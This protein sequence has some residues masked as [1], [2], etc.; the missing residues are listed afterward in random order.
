M[1]K[2][3]ILVR[4][5]EIYLKGKNKP[6]FEKMLI[7]NIKKAIPD[8]AF[9]V[10][11]ISGRFLVSNYDVIKEK[12]LMSKL[13]KVFG[14]YSISSTVEMDTSVDEIRSYCREIKILESTFKVDVNRADKT[15]PIR[16]VPFAADLGGYVLENNPKLKVKL[17]DP[18]KIVFVDIRENGKTYIFYDIIKGVGGLPVG[19]SGRGLLLLSGGIDS[20]VAGYLMAKRGLSIDA[21]YFHSFPYT[22]E[23]VKE[24]VKKLAGILS[25][26]SGK[27][28]L[29]VVSFTKVQESIHEKCRPEYM[30][31]IMRRFMMRIARKLCAQN[32]LK[33]IITGESLAQVASQTVESMTVTGGVI[34]D[35]PV[36]RPLIGNDKEET[37]ELSEK[38]GAYETSILP[39][40]DCCTVF[41]PEHPLIKPK[42]D[43]VEKEES[44]LDINSLI[45][46]AMENIEIFDI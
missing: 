6:F 19:V 45:E 35:I 44:Y 33:C 3:C 2:H 12:H 31:T 27:I 28:R 14:I 7:N 32:H 40:Q 21:V 42:L 22:G 34:T 39:Y 24:K 13:Q 41:L 30:I 16:S 46:G 5:G 9:Q 1:I 37:I 4:Y 10:S 38:M 25:E 26:Y 17:T 20:P 18:D 43:K 23:R 36:F 8:I 11:R 15:F 29:H